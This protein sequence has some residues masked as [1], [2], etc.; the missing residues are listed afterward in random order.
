M[1]V[2][3]DVLETFGFIK[4]VGVMSND[5]IGFTA[6]DQDGEL[7]L[8][9]DDSGMEFTV[10]TAGIF[11]FDVSITTDTWNQFV[12]GFRSIDEAITWIIEGV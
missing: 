5:A 8:V 9:K 2:H 7:V 11:E 6:F 1:F 4:D 10:T 12:P 3:E